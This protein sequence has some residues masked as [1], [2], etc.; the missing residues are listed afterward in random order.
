MRT[1]IVR[2]GNSKGIRIP[3]PLL[4]ESGITGD[5]DIT[6]KRGELKIRPINPKLTPTETALLSE[7]AFARDWNRPEEEEAWKSLQ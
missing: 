7:K 1:T 6:A 5:V 3:K 4:K 2:I